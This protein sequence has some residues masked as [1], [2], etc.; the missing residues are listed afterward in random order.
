MVKAKQF[1]FRIYE[2]E[3]DT[4][5]QFDSF[6]EE[7]FNNT[8]LLDNFTNNGII[9]IIFGNSIDEYFNHCKS[10]TKL[11]AVG[12][13]YDHSSVKTT[14]V[15]FSEEYDN[16]S[17]NYHYMVSPFV[18][19]IKKLHEEYYNKHKSSFITFIYEHGE[20]IEFDED[21]NNNPIDFNN[22]YFSSI[23]NIN[24]YFD[25][26]ALYLSS[27]NKE[28]FF[29]PIIN[30][31]MFLETDKNLYYTRK[32][33]V[34]VK[35]QISRK[36]PI[37]LDNFRSVFDYF[38]HEKNFENYNS[39]MEDIPNLFLQAQ[40]EENKWIKYYLLFTVLELLIQKKFN[41]RYER[42][43]EEL[44]NAYENNDIS[45][46]N[47]SDILK[48]KINSNINNLVK[49]DFSLGDKFF[50]ISKEYS[51]SENNELEIFNKL[52]KDRNNMSHGRSVNVEELN[53]PAIVQILT[54]YLN[55]FTS[56]DNFNEELLKNDE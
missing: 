53:I 37:P 33:H 19:A 42:Y 25:L 40:F 12:H 56:F 15:D 36:T 13:N 4:K 22:F 30:G 10:I 17:D 35:P 50:F 45:D 1:V 44:R 9:K 20:E 55:K 8:F 11:I 31:E 34:N 41:E 28:L 29:K 5:K 32:F 54:K 23:H 38:N 16:K 49:N 3:K 18:P 7:C 14:L 39:W 52:K 43:L 51:G 21:I 48:D 27:I 24:K 6:F 2:F 46:F 26:L 47:L